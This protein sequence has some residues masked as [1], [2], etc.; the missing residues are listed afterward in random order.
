MLGLWRR[1]L[2]LLLMDIRLRRGEPVGSTRVPTGTHGEEILFFRN[3]SA[4]LRIQP[5]CPL[6][7]MVP[8][9]GE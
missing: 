4:L 8:E 3:Y 6:N 2:R 7:I 5:K 1:Q 9:G